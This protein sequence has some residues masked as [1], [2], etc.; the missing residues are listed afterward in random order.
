MPIE[1][2]SKRNTAGCIAR[3]LSSNHIHTDQ[4]KM[5]HSFHKQ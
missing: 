2:I 1:E 5:K 3:I 4:L